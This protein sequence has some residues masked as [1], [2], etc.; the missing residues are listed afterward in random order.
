MQC[1]H[2][3]HKIKRYS[4]YDRLDQCT[5]CFQFRRVTRIDP[6]HEKHTFPATGI[7]RIVTV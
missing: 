1:K 4:K 6:G 7:T 2:Q 5:V 3:W